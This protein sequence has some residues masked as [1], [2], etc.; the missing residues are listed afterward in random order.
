[1]EELVEKIYVAITNRQYVR[2]SPKGDFRE[3]VLNKIKTVI[4]RQE[5]VI[6]VIGFGYHKNPNACDNLLPDIAEKTAISRLVEYASLVEE[7]YSPGVKIKI[8]TTGEKAEIVNG[9]DPRNTLAYHLALQKMAKENEWEESIEIIPIGDLYSEFRREFQ[10]ALREIRDK[11][12]PDWNS[13]FWTQQ[14]E[15]ARRNI[16]KDGLTESEILEEGRR[17]AYDYVLYHRAE[18]KAGLLEKKWL[19]HIRASYNRH[20]ESIVFWTTAKGAITQPWQGDGFVDSNG[21]VTVMTQGRLKK[22][23]KA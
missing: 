22:I 7:V 14:A 8:I 3:A 15:H 4:D 6:L 13:L 5:S 20:K 23:R 21:G 1:M 11:I 10:L 2:Y 19:G 16:R 18:M 9:M 12:K 17:A